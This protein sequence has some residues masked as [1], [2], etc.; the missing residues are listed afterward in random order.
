MAGRGNKKRSSRLVEVPKEWSAK[1][2][3]QIVLR[4]KNEKTAEDANMGISENLKIKG[5]FTEKSTSTNLAKLD[6]SHF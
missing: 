3:L 4:G 2:E 5:I 1:I 6:I